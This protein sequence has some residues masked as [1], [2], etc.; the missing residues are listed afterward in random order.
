MAQYLA[1]GVFVDE[2]D[3]SAYIPSVSTSVAAFVGE[4]EWGPAYS[5]V[6]LTNKGQ[7]EQIFGKPTETNYEDW[8]T[9]YNFLSYSTTLKLVRAINRT[10]A[11]NATASGTGVLIRDFDDWS[12]NWASGQGGS[13]YGSWACKSASTKGNSLLVSLCGPGAAFNGAMTTTATTT[14][15]NAIIFFSANVKTDATRPM[16]VGD[17]IRYGNCNNWLEV[18]S[19]NTAGIQVTVNTSNLVISSLA[20]SAVVARWQFASKFG[21]APGTSTRAEKLGAAN[22]EVHVVVMGLFD[23]FSRGSNGGGRANTIVDKW[24]GL[25]VAHGSQ[26]HG[27]SNYYKE[28]I[29]RN[30]RHIYW[31]GHPTGATN[32]GNA[33]IVN[34]APQSFTV[35]SA[36][37][38]SYLSG[39]VYAAPSD[40]DIIEAYNL[41]VDKNQQDVSFLLTGSHSQTIKKWVLENISISRGDCVT[42]IC[43]QKASVVGVHDASV[44]PLVLA[45]RDFYPS[46]SFGFYVDNWKNQFDPYNDVYRW[47]PIDADIAGIAAQTDDALDAWWS[48]AGF[49]RGHIKNAGKLAWKTDDGLREELYPKGINSIV[50]FPNEGTILYGDRTMQIKPSAFDRINVRRLFITIE[51]AIS[52]AAKYLLFEFNDAFT[53]AQFVAMIEPYLREIQGRRGIYDFRVVCDETNNPG[54]VIDHN[55]F[56]GDI[57]IKPARSINFLQLNFVAVRTDVVFEE[58]AGKFGG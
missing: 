2:I 16:Q 43:P 37:V 39:G 51:K 53:R 7:L 47:L 56:V 46:T 33:Y 17:Q 45:D 13:T 34:T 5:I 49:N 11:K 54:E 41:F 40:G 50:R 4:F 30:G 24:E 8:F 9:A 21:Y 12:E 10:L 35:L 55:Q 32:W 15:G 52:A 48:F 42:F 57:Y 19:I 38:N 26:N 25:S 31:M 18:V 3:L 14:T 27:K 1:P 20:G 58:I 22:D 36:P 44:L 29:S 28:I 6:T 23:Q